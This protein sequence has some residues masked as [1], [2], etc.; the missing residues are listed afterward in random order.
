MTLSNQRGFLNTFAA[1]IG[2]VILAA[3]A[4]YL[5]IS[6]GPSP[7]TIGEEPPIGGPIGGTVCTQE[8]MLCPDGSYVG[9]TGPNCE[10]AP[11][12]GGSTGT[13]GSSGASGSAG[14]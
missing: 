9:R 6:R 10:F 11:C 12:G 7:S 1:A 2:V 13:Q 8:A 4:G 3:V 14:A 5:I